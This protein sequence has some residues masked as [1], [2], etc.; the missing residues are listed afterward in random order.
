MG[1]R[2]R[3]SRGRVGSCRC[4]HFGMLLDWFGVRFIMWCSEIGECQNFGSPTSRAYFGSPTSL[5]PHHY[6]PFSYRRATGVQNLIRTLDPV[7]KGC[8]SHTRYHMIVHALETF[9]H[10]R[11]AVCRHSGAEYE[12]PPMHPNVGKSCRHAMTAQRTRVGRMRSH[13]RLPRCPRAGG[14]A[15]GRGTHAA[16]TRAPCLQ[17]SRLGHAAGH[18][19]EAVRAGLL[20]ESCEPAHDK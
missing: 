9:G 20:H 10:P 14:A 18:C 2:E 5:P 15:H 11:F 4:V 16:P 12:P 8:A 7:S 3:A 19:R 13:A 1:G 6:P 17:L